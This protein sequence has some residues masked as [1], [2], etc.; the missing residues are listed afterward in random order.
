M[1]GTRCC[2]S[3]TQA[4]H[5]NPTGAEIMHSGQIGREHRAQTMRVSRLGCR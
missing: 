3:A 1:R 4:G 2:A 5:W